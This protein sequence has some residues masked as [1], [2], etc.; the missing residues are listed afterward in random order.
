MMAQLVEYQTRNQE[1][2]ISSQT[3]L[4]CSE[5][6]KVIQTYVPPSPSSII[7]T[8]L[9]VVIPYGWEGYRGSGRM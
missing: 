2:R 3:T 8:G 5:L 4:R 9:R 6:E 7:C 1:I